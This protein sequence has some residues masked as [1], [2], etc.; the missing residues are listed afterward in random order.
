MTGML[1]LPVRVYLEDT[2]AQGVVYNASYIR[3]FERA[4]T[5]W[6]RSRGIDHNDLRKNTNLMLVLSSIEARFR[7]PAKL[8][9]MLQVSA[10]VAEVSA[11][12]F[13]F[14]QD[15]RR[16]TTDGELLCDGVAQVACVDTRTGR[17][18]RLPEYVIADL[19]KDVLEG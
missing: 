18:R 14:N 8:D 12:R 19:N 15:I 5:E 17:P 1:I 11:V 16:E 10:R 2:D 3:F 9:D 7:V 6:L 13:L 4:R